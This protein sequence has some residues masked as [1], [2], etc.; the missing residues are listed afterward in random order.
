MQFSRRTG[1]YDSQG[2]NWQPDEESSSDML[3]DGAPVELEEGP[4]M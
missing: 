3:M 2:E 1:F 4:P